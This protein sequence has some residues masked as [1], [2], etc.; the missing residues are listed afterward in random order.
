[1]KILY[2]KFKNHE[3]KEI[4]RTNPDSEH[5]EEEQMKYLLKEYKEADSLGYLLEWRDE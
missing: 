1:M 3:W 5:T 4:D 2:G